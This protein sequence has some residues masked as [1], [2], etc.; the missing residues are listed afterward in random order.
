MKLYELITTT[1]TQGK[2]DGVF[3]HS[4]ER[5]NHEKFEKSGGGYYAHVEKSDDPHMINK[6]THYSIPVEKDSYFAYIKKIVNDELMSKNPFFPRIYSV[7]TTVDK[8]KKLHY[9]IEMEQLYHLKELSQVELNALYNNI[10]GLDTKKEITPILLAK[11]VSGLVDNPTRA[12]K[13]ANK[14]FINAAKIIKEISLSIPAYIDL[15][16]NNMMVRRTPFGYQLVLT[17]PLAEAFS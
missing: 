3:D 13:T 10:I 7:D 11:T 14:K 12:P 4:V 6:Q 5:N 17:D 15:H 2:H 1:K 9:K 16:A 8:E